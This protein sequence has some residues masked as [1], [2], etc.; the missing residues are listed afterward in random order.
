MRNNCW[1]MRPGPT[2]H[3]NLPIWSLTPLNVVVIWTWIVPPGSLRG[4]PHAFSANHVFTMR[5]L[6]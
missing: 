5:D 6:S 4:L 1:L 3:H 2:E